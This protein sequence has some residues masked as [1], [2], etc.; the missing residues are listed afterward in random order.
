MLASPPQLGSEL[1]CAQPGPLSRLTQLGVHKKKEAFGHL[2]ASYSTGSLGLGAKLAGA[3]ASLCR[4]R[5]C[6]RRP[7]EWLARRR[8]GTS[9]GDRVRLS[10]SRTH[11]NSGRIVEQRTHENGAANVAASPGFSDLYLSGGYRAISARDSSPHDPFTLRRACL[12]QE[13]FVRVVGSS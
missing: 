3:P 9:D 1:S 13:R 6:W 5:R 12:A 11:A 10:H 4:S 7:P 2:V 8:S